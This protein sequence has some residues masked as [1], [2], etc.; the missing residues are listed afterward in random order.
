VGHKKHTQTFYHNV[1][2]TSLILIEIDAEIWTL[3][4]VNKNNIGS[5]AYVIFSAAQIAWLI[6][7]F[8][9]YY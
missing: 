9:W 3:I 4:L 7:A 2:N 5:S 1:Y 6:N 8:C